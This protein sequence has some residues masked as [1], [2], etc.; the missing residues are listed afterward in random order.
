M[1]SQAMSNIIHKN[2]SELRNLF[3]QQRN[4]LDSKALSRGALL[5]RGRL[6]AWVSSNQTL[7]KEQGRKPFKTIAAYWP[8]QNEPDLIPLLRQLSKDYGYD[9][10]LPVVMGKDKPLQFNVWQPDS[11]MQTGDY[12]I[13]YPIGPVA[14][15]PDIMLVPTLGFTRNGDRIGYGGGYYDRTIHHIRQ[16]NPNCITIGVAWACN[17][18]NDAVYS[19]LL[20]YE[21]QK[22]DQQ[23]DA[24]ITDMGWAK[25]APQL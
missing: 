24:I 22:H 6:F 25:P 14:A 23:L 2:L 12:G 10:C 15:S 19:D 16:N 1:C 21:P 4:N 3:K 11:E 18:I 5:M 7:L 8:I 9:V 20:P 13:P 17:D